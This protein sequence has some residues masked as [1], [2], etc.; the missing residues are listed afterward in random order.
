MAQATGVAQ[1]C[2]IR[3]E[4]TLARVVGGL[5][6]HL[7]ETETFGTAAAILDSEQSGI[8]EK[9]QTESTLGKGRPT[10]TSNRKV[11][12]KYRIPDCG[13]AANVDYAFD[14]TEGTPTPDNYGYD[15]MRIE[16]FVSDRFAVGVALS[17]DNCEDVQELS[18]IHI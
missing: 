1:L 6:P 8:L 14:C 17:D 16:D 18:L 15:E 9:V 13:D 12:V 2:C 10:P 4:Q 3:T 5:A 11:T 7:V